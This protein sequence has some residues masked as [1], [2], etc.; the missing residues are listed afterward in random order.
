MELEEKIRDKI[1]GAGEGK[2][3]SGEQQQAR[4]KNA[5]TLFVADKRSEMMAQHPGITFY[6]MN[7]MLSIKWMALTKQTKQI[8]QRKFREITKLREE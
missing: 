5:Y 1:N 4:P 2:D 6:K 7:Q 8:Y 3:C